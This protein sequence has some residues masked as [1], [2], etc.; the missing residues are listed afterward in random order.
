MIEITLSPVFVGPKN[1]VQIL[2]TQI[3]V[4]VIVFKKK[5]QGAEVSLASQLYFLLL[6]ISR[7]DYK[8]SN[9]DS[10]E[11]PHPLLH[12]HIKSLIP[13]SRAVTFCV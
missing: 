4:A 1:V 6:L 5:I 13:S 12:S 8:N 2:F 7:F 9:Q 10:T 11:G 3:I